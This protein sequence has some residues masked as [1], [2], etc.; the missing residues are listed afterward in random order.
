[1]VVAL[2]RVGSA[3]PPQRVVWVLAGM[4]ALGL[5]GALTSLPASGSCGGG[6]GGSGGTGSTQPLDFGYNPLQHASGEAA[7][8]DTPPPLRRPEFKAVENANQ[9]KYEQM[10]TGDNTYQKGSCWGCRFV[11]DLVTKLD[12]HTVLDAG[13]GA[14]M[15]SAASGVHM[16]A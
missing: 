4:A 12:F 15:E 5:L 14:G 9:E 6:G 7:S 16:S 8:S 2:A 13:A 1:M 10:W 3:W 11:G